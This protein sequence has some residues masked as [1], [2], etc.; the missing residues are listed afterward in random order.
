M[1]RLADMGYRLRRTILI[2]GLVCLTGGLVWI[3][4]P[5]WDRGAGLG[6]TPALIDGSGNAYFVNILVYVGLFLLTQWLFL[7]PR[8]DIAI[9][10]SASGR[11]MKSAIIGAAFAAMMLTVAWFATLME[12]PDWWESMGDTIGLIGFWIAMA[13]VW[14][15][16]AVVFGIYWRQGDRYTQLGRMARGLLVGSTLGLLVAIP[17]Q[18]VTAHRDDCYCARGSYTGLV[19]GGTVLLWAFGPGVVLLYLR[20]RRRAIGSTDTHTQ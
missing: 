4:L 13:V 10:L 9:Q 6:G 16:W 18:I 19:F 3:L 7:R 5:L 1:S 11:P 12:I 17:V 15:V 14:V 8:R 2:V 20:E